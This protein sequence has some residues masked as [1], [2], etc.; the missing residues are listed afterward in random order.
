[1][2]KFNHVILDIETNGLLDVVSVV[3]SIVVMDVHT[4]EIR[5]F[6]D[7]PGYPSIADGIKLLE[8][9]K[10]I[11]GHNIIKY[12]LPVLQKLH[13]LKKHYSQVYDT[14]VIARTAYPDLM[15]FDCTTELPKSI[16][17]R[18]SLKAWG[19]RIG[20]LKGEFGGE[21]ES[22]E[23]WSEEMQRYCEQDVKVT[24]ALMKWLQNE[25]I[26]KLALEIEHTL[27][28][29]L[30]SQEQGGFPFNKEKAEELAA[31]LE[32]EESRLLKELQGFFGLSIKRG[33]YVIP[34]ANRGR[35]G[36]KKSTLFTVA[37]GCSYCKMEVMEY[38]GGPDQTKAALKRLYNW[39][40]NI[41]KKRKRVGGEMQAVREEEG[42]DEATLSKLDFPCIPTLIAYNN[43]KKIKGMLTNG[44]NAWLRLQNPNTGNIHGIVNQNATITHRATHV[45]PNV[46]Q[47]P[48]GKRPYGKECRELFYAPEGWTIIGTDASGLELRMLAHY[49]AVYDQG[50]Y[51]KVI[52]E[53]D[54]HSE[55]QKAAGL[56]TRNHA[57][58]FIYGF[59]YGAGAAKIGSI[60][61]P[62][63]DDRTQAIAGQDIKNKFLASLPALSQVIE[64]CVTEATEKGYVISIDGRKTYVKSAH[65]ALNCLLQSSGSISVKLWMTLFYKELLEKFGEPGWG[66]VWTPLSWSHDDALVAVKNEYVE[67]IQSIILSNIT[68]A[69]ELLNL[70]IRLD[71]E[72]KTGTNWYEVH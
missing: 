66:G 19:H 53:G 31:H 42:T 15:P 7:Q 2:S 65:K 43:V 72:S 33:D 9:A 36:D 49:M 17:G 27:A 56:P 30:H 55:N 11:T 67:Q 40:P 14:L 39:E 38:T 70:N 13:G 51:G 34:K 54:I 21:E 8:R 69:G 25:D 3:H 20:E 6:A 59:L 5:S 37:K 16:W 22:W 47:V 60:I 28:H 29:Y 62:T 46:S 58:S 48:S 68:K 61:A 52:L 23:T 35:I 18:H 1:M 12:D 4:Q 24:Y 57:K 10:S 41:I 64:D 26:P 50:A 44:T 45:R 32:K 63:A 71:G